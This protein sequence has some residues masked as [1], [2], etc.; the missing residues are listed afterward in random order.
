VADEITFDDITVKYLSIGEARS[1]PGLRLV[2][3]AYALPGPWR[4]SCKG[5]FDVKGIAYDSV[6]CSNEGASD[7]LF[8]ANGTHSELIDWTAQS[9]APVAIWEDQRPRASWIDQ[10]FLAERLQPEP[11]LIP[12]DYE[13]RLRMFGLITEIAGDDGLGWNK[14][15]LLVHRNLKTAAPGTP[16]HDFWTTIG[17]KYAY[18]EAAGERAHPRMI[19]ILDHLTQELRAQKARGSSYLIGDRLS[20]VDIYA[21]CFYA[22]FEPLPPE[23][24]PMATSYRGAYCPDDAEVKSAMSPELAAHRLFIYQNHLTLPI[25]F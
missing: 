18:T 15:Q 25:V 13:D 16:E 22:L 5:L 6:R 9:G 8:G 11:R 19:E 17:G 3:G 2:L 4:E 10:L 23:L 1:R 14:R 12:A 24:C 7:I 20:A 21:A